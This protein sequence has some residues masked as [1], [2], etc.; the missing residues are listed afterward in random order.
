MD[1]LKGKKAIMIVDLPKKNLHIRDRV[2]ILRS[3]K[4]QLFI[5]QDHLG[6]RRRL[7][8]KSLETPDIEADIDFADV[9]IKE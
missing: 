1:K 2:E 5:G 7:R 4:E 3:W 9:L 6:T 8:I